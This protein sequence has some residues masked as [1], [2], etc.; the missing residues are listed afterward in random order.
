LILGTAIP[1]G[2]GGEE[3]F[4][5]WTARA[6]RAPELVEEDEAAEPGGNGVF[7][8]AGT[9][10]T[11]ERKL[12]LVEEL[13]PRAMH[14][15]LIPVVIRRKRVYSR[16]GEGASF[17][18]ACPTGRKGELPLHNIPGSARDRGS[19]ARIPP[20]GDMRKKSYMLNC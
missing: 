2:E 18:I 7:G 15:S 1:D 8:A 10:P 4:G 16:R 20:G 6:G 12:E 14:G 3:G 11:A 5:L 19:C 9:T 17:H 13:G